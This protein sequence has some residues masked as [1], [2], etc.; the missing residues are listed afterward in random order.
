MPNAVSGLAI[1]RS[2]D[3]TIRR[4][5]GRLTVLLLLQTQLE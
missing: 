3:R 1:A 2:D 4:S 5:D